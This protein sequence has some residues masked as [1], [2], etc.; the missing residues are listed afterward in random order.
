MSWMGE[1]VGP[2][3]L[4]SIFQKVFLFSIEVH[5]YCNSSAAKAKL[6]CIAICVVEMCEVFN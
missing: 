2:V 4:A 6:E 5:F 3:A 1:E